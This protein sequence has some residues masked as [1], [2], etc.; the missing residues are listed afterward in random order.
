MTWSLGQSNA[1]VV[2]PTGTKAAARSCMNALHS[3]TLV[4]RCPAAVVADPCLVQQLGF[5]WSRMKAFKIRI[6]T[7]RKKLTTIEQFQRQGLER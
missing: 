4:R 3:L 6:H 7:E 2:I 5:L 1:L